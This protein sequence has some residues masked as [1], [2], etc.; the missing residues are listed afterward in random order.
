MTSLFKQIKN[1]KSTKI[2]ASNLR[3]DELVK[4]DIV[5][6]LK[7]KFSE[8]GEIITTL[9]RFHIIPKRGASKEIKTK[10]DKKIS[11]VIKTMDSIILEHPTPEDIKQKVVTITA[12]NSK[13]LEK[14][15]K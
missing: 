10:K 15:L 3:L 13:I 9:V 8:E 11:I 6:D 7:A 2:I 1:P 14:F 4:N 12:T 5:K